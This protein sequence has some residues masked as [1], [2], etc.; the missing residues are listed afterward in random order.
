MKKCI[1][2]V[3]LLL[4]GCYTV[5]KANRQVLKAQA[6]FPELVAA[7]CGN[8]YPPK[9]TTVTKTEYKPGV[10]VYSRDTVRLDCDSALKA[11]KGGKVI[12]IPYPV[13]NERVD[14]F[15]TTRTV[16]VENTAKIAALQAEIN[17]E[18]KKAADLKWERNH[19]RMLA[20]VCT[21]LIAAHFIVKWVVR[22]I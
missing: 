19:W 13:T 9:E 7:N 11:G 15:Y 21:V 1:I 6:H 2:P 16:T 20:I 22:T 3:A 18:S 5:K 8:W 4:C 10:P 14:T 12:K 17:S